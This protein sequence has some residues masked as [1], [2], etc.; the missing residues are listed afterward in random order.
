MCIYSPTTM[1]LGWITNTICHDGLFP[2]FDYFSNLKVQKI[3]W[4]KWSCHFIKR[5]QILFTSTQVQAYP[6]AS[7]WHS[8]HIRK[9][10]LDFRDVRM[11]PNQ[12]NYLFNWFLLIGFV[13]GWDFSIGLF[14]RIS[15]TNWGNYLCSDTC[16]WLMKTFPIQLLPPFWIIRCF[17]YFN[18]D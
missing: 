4:S 6:A 13:R 11:Q 2:C 5:L 18:L 9:C 3:D 12:L 1:V 7:V 10:I 17:R 16:P 14:F 8:G 15:S